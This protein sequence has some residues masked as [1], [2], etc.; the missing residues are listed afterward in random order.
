MLMSLF[1]F[2]VFDLYFC[3]KVKVFELLTKFWH[4][5]RLKIK[6][7]GNFRKSNMSYHFSIIVT[8]WWLCCP[9]SSL[10]VL[11]LQNLCETPRLNREV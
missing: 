8:S 11:R 5:G 7:Y 6:S 10:T 9:C 4:L 1:M 3:V 2:I